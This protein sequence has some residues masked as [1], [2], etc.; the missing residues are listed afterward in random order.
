MK[1]RCHHT[2]RHVWYTFDRASG[3]LLCTQCAIFYPPVFRRSLAI[4]VVVGSMLTIINQGD[5]LLRGSITALVVVKI[6]LTYMVPL[7]V[8]TISALAA[9]R[10]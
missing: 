9:N 5:V 10:V 1:S 3:R 4:S 7:C 2:K 6:C 8:A